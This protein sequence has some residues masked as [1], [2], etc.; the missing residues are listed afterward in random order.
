MVDKNYISF[1]QRDKIIYI[2]RLV[3]GVSEESARKGLS[4]EFIKWLEEQ[5]KLNG[6]VLPDSEIPKIETLAN[7]KVIWICECCFPR[8]D[9]GIHEVTQCEY[10][11][12]WF[13]EKHI[14]LIR[15]NISMGINA[16]VLK[17]KNNYLRM[18]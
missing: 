12:K 3:R 14:D 7:G 13:C 10:C 5:K 6:M 8:G 15:K 1:I 16:L 18:L 11:D 17:S 9:I 4:Q 2:G